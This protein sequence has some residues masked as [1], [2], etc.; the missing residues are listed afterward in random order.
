MYCGYILQNH[1]LPLALGC[2]GYEE[3]NI[4]LLRYKLFFAR[5]KHL[6]IYGELKDTYREILDEFGVQYTVFEDYSKRSR[7]GEFK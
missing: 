6:M 5:P 1:P 3:L 7:K 4:T 2:G